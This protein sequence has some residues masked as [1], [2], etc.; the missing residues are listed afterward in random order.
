MGGQ[1]IM[2]P[3]VRGSNHNH[4]EE[5]VTY[6]YLENTQYEQHLFCFSVALSGYR[7]FC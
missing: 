6:V 1:E 2:F 3:V 4:N 7:R 5:E